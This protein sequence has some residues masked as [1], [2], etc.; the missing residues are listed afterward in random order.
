MTLENRSLSVQYELKPIGTI[1]A[2]TLD[3]RAMQHMTA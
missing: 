1:I 2:N 3:L